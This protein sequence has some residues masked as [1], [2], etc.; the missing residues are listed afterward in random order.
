MLKRHMKKQLTILF[1]EFFL[2]DTGTKQQIINIQVMI[3]LTTSVMLLKNLLK[4][5]MKL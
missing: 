4:E 3:I 2:R 1:K 5:L